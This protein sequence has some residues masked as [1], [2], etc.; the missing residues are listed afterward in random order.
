MPI[1]P[2]AGWPDEAAGMVTGVEHSDDTAV[3][4]HVTPAVVAGGLVR[5]DEPA[6]VVPPP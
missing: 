3:V 1:V 5:R 4:L 2:I 6:V